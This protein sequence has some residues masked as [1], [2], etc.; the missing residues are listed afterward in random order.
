MNPRYPTL[1][2]DRPEYNPVDY[3]NVFIDNVVDEYTSTTD[4]ES[5]TDENAEASIWPEFLDFL[6]WAGITVKTS[7]FT[8]FPFLEW[9]NNIS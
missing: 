5:E 1:P 3:I 2:V 7:L 6:T 8:V 9:D 4:S